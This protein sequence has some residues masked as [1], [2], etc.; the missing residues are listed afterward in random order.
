MFGNRKRIAELEVQ[1]NELS[2]QALGLTYLIDVI[3][4]P[5]T[6]VNNNYVVWADKCYHE[7]RVK[8]LGDICYYCGGHNS[9]WE[10]KIISDDDISFIIRIDVWPNYYLYLRPYDENGETEEPKPE[11]CYYKIYKRDGNREVLNPEYIENL[12]KILNKD[13]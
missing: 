10:S 1:V 5:T 13:K 6:I 11:K 12:Y 9:K 2:K 8:K 7:I 3:P 4:I